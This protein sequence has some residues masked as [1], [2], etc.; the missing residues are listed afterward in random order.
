MIK[1]SPRYP[2]K[3][4]LSVVCNV[5]FIIEPELMRI[6]NPHHS[7]MGFA[8]PIVIGIKSSLLQEASQE[9]FYD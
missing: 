3:G 4:R 5:Y 9:I 2:T 6:Y 8:I 1:S 7:D